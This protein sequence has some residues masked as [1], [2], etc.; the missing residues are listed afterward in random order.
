M[1]QFEHLYRFADLFR[2]GE[3]LFRSLLRV[4]FLKTEVVDRLYG[5]LLIRGGDDLGLVVL[6]CT[7]LEEV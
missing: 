5:V 6:K 3:K 2:G 7:G 4:D 1:S